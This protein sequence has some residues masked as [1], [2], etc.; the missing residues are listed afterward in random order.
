MLFL[1]NKF[2]SVRLCGEKNGQKASKEVIVAHIFKAFKIV[3][4][5]RQV[6]S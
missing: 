1:R 2:K 6:F 5:N 3:D 4:F